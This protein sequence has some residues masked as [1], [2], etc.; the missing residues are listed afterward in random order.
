MLAVG[1]HIDVARLEAT[2]AEVCSWVVV[3]VVVVAILKILDV[4]AL[5]LIT[6]EH[7]PHASRYC[8]KVLLVPG[9]SAVGLGLVE[10]VAS[11]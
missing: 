1:S 10:H 4:G 5:V 7:E 8:V 3:E 6:G 2:V 9:L 11:S